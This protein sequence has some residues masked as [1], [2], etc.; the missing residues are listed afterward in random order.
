M[1]AG[2]TA[3]VPVATSDPTALPTFAAGPVGAVA[4]VS[5]ALLLAFASRYGYHRDE[6]YFFERVPSSRLRLRRPT[7]GCGA[8]GVACPR[9]VR[10]HAA[11]PAR[12]PRAAQW[13]GRRSDG[14]DDEGARGIALRAGVRRAVRRHGRTAGR[15]S[16]R[17]SDG[18]RRV[19]VGA[20]V[21][22][23]ASHPAHR[24]RAALAVGRDGRRRRAGSQ[25]HDPAPARR[26]CR[27]VRGRPTVPDLPQSVA[28]GRRGGCVRP[29]GA[30]PHLAGHERLADD[31]DGR[32]PPRRALGPRVRRQVSVRHAPRAR[33]LRRSGLDVGRVGT[34]ARP[35]NDPVPRVRRGVR[36]RVRRVVGRDPGSL[37]LP[38]RDLSGVDRGGGA[39]HRTGG[40]RCA[41]LLP[42]RATTPSVVAIAPLGRR[43]RGRQR[44]VAAPRRAPRLAVVRARVGT[45]AEG[46][47][48][49]RG[50]DRMAGS[51]P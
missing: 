45:P 38:V 2:P 48:Q 11:R 12:H 4:V 19:R 31:T 40:G 13:W 16:P 51:H 32:E 7:T 35:P 24:Q 28:V 8:R 36:V 6:L 3:G 47:L 20:D 46:Q 18:V 10:E 15:G 17:G 42:S 27:G 23:G 49:P 50:R 37:L 26:A 14:R 22:A 30:E 9:R 1:S 43:P 5:T 25:G 41:R 34:L 21:L 33:G 29:V 44:R 39:D